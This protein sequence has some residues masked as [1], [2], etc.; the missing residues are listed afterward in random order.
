MT[1]PGGELTIEW[2][3]RDDHVLMT[4]PVEFEFTGKFDPALFAKSR[5]RGAMSVDIVTFGCRLN[6]AESEV[7]RREAAKAGL[8]DAVVVNTCAVTARSR[9][10]GAP[11]HP[12]HQ[13]R[14]PGCAHRRHRL[15]GAGRAAAASPPCRKSIACSAT[16]KSSTR[17]L[18]RRRRA[19]RRS[20]TSWR[21]ERACGRTRSITS[22]ATPAPSCRCRTAATIAAPSASSRSAAAIRAR[23]RST[24]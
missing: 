24:M 10:P 19:R 15:R 9:A 12:P 7:I 21:V 23:C 8:D 4:G 5:V 22:T 2:R 3:E 6:I 11:D 18:G 13:A 14:A 1:L 20:A 16:K 17:A